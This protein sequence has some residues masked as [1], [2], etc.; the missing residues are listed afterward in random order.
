MNRLLTFTV[1]ALLLTPHLASSQS[2]D[3]CAPT[4]RMGKYRFLRQLTLD[5]YGRVPTIDEY[6]R[7]HER[8][9]VDEAL[10]DEM[11]GSTEFFDNLAAY[12]RGLL[13][14]SLPDDD[15]LFA[16]TIEE[17]SATDNSE[18][19][20]WAMRNKQSRYR[21][22]Y[23]ACL[24][25]PHTNFDASGK[26]LPMQGNF[27]GSSSCED[28]TDDDTGA[29]IGCRMDGWVEVEPYWAPGTMLKVCAFDAQSAATE[30]P[31]TYCS[32]YDNNPDCGCG[33]GLLYC[34][35]AGDEGNA[36]E[37]RKALTEEPARIFEGVIRAGRPYTEAFETTDTY[38][39]GALRHYYRYL[40]RKAEGELR[41]IAGAPYDAD[42]EIV[43]RPD[44]HA[45]IL[46]TMGFLLRFTT[47]RARV[48]QLY[49]KFLCDPFQAPA[50]GLPPAT[51]A[52]SLNPDLSERC[53][54]ASCHQTI[55][56]ATTFFG[57]W[58]EGDFEFQDELEEFRQDC[59][60]CTAGSGT[61][62]NCDRAGYVTRDLETE[63]GNVDSELGKL[64]VLAWRSSSEANGFSQGPRGLVRQAGYQERLAQCTVQTF[65][66]FVF[67]RALSTNEKAG[68][69]QEA[70]GR[71]ASNGHDFLQMARD[72]LLDPRY[73]RID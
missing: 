69:L 41:G 29:V 45:G 49:D 17:R 63:P 39:N 52:C 6:E 68:W 1:A 37:I 8:D 27:T 14:T 9:D 59:A 53:G 11:L 50:G 12:H 32:T 21:R 40:Q 44:H 15:D 23:T 72:I 5:L 3:Y 42:W 35:G 33:A 47:Q 34:A 26:P 25:T 60:D 24:D 43:Q 38:F 58:E 55:E 51:D 30:E 64:K 62:Q 36:A 10:I 19:R 22:A 57:R 54:C 66:E 7:L 71:F 48:N 31:G 73:R 70:T 46:T 20:V 4:D 2:P 16:M 28:V 13:W 67:G 18:A 56:P 65:S 61:C